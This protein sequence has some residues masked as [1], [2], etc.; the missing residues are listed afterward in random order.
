MTGPGNAGTRFI[1]SA[2]H[3]ISDALRRSACSTATGEK[4]AD[5]NQSE[6]N[7][8]V[9]HGMVILPK[10]IQAS[11]LGSETIC[12]SLRLENCISSEL[13]AHAEI[14]TQITQTKTLPAG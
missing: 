14:K 7:E 4:S 10:S 12:P 13:K 5:S 2:V 1:G 6:G 11:S 9:F 8:E 3:F